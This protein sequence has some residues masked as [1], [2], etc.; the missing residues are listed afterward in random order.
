MSQLAELYSI[1]EVGTEEKEVKL[2]PDQ[3]KISR[4][5]NANFPTGEFFEMFFV[6]GDDDYSWSRP[7]LTFSKTSRVS[8]K[9]IFLAFLVWE[10]AAAGFKAS[11]PPSSTTSALDATGL[12]RIASSVSIFESFFFICTNSLPSG[13]LSRQFF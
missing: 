13:R 1:H 10:F 6:P 9:V 3:S 8:S 4:T 11:Q 5:F 7:V 2:N 12:K